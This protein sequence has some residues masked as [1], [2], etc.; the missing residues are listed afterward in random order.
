MNLLHGRLIADSPLTEDAHSKTWLGADEDLRPCLIRVWPFGLDRPDTAIRALWSREE[1][2]LRR[3]ASISGAED[4]LLTHLDGGLDYEN[5]AFVMALSTTGG[6]F[7]PLADQLQPRHGALAFTSLRH[8]SQRAIVW[9]ALA[10]LARGI[11]L[12]HRQ[13]ILHQSIG[14]ENVFGNPAIGPSSWRLGGFEWAFRFGSE[15]PAAVVSPRWAGLPSALQDGVSFAADWYLFG[16]LAA[17]IFCNV[18]SIAA[19][20]A[21]QRHPVLLREAENGG[22]SQLQQ[23]ERAL[24]LRLLGFRAADR[25]V[26]GE[27]LIDEIL[28]LAQGLVA[29]TLELNPDVPFV[30]IFNPRN[31][32]LTDACRA[33]GFD[34][35]GDEITPFNFEDVSHVDALR[36]FL[37]EDLQA[38]VLHRQPEGDAA[39]LC[40]SRLTLFIIPYAERQGGVLS[41]PSWDFAF[42]ADPSE[43]TGSDPED[44]RDLSGLK[45]LPVSQQSRRGVS[46]S[47]PWTAVL[48][49]TQPA[50][51]RHLA[52][53]LARMHNFVRCTNQLDLL[54]TSARIFPFEEVPVS[55][56]VAPRSAEARSWEELFIREAPREFELPGWARTQGGLAGMLIEEISSEKDRCR[57]V[58]LTEHSR[59][60][61]GRQPADEEWWDAEMGEDGR[62]IHL[63]RPLVPGRILPVLRRGFVRTFGLWGQFSLVERRQRAIDRLKDHRFLLRVL[64][65]PV[66]RDS[67]VFNDHLP[68][69]HLAEIQG[70]G[71]GRCGARPADI[72][73]ARPSGNGQDH[74]RVAAPAARVR[75]AAGGAGSRHRASPRRS[76]CFAKESARRGLQGQGGSCQTTVHPPRRV[77][78][79]R[80]RRRFHSKRHPPIAGDQSGNDG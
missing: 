19:L 77:G 64:A 2:R 32:G 54:I 75:G 13:R 1:R 17:R 76:G 66:C 30:L 16:T 27:Q 6:G 39:I 72:C 31:E 62:T 29:G 49:R 40:G 22:S 61:T 73:V 9:E 24:L 78:R 63:R 8:P 33:A 79:W 74:L 14:A 7:A 70:R 21:D 65:S 80:A 10:R 25:L 45:I 5:R 12:M 37:E 58:L 3:L 15:V 69:P 11:H 51:E 44:Q 18:E 53:D 35:A 55:E 68:I 50:E 42:L 34:P 43:V 67:K 56:P 47:Q 20:P 48:P 59:L 60:S 38:A 41:K 26:I 28:A 4:A 57:Q 46:R 71:H 23:R 52:L 36:A